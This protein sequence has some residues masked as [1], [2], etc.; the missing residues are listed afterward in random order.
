[1]TATLNAQGGAAGGDDFDG[2]VV[3]QKL[4]L[5]VPVADV[6]D[7]VKEQVGRLAMVGQGLKVAGVTLYST[8]AVM[9]RMG[10][11]ISSV[12]ATW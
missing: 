11:S 5:V 2:G 1:M 7:F 4:E 9:R 8:Q 6:L 3:D 12:T 10:S